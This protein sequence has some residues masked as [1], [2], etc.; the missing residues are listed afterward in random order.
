MNATASV[1]HVGDSLQDF[2]PERQS[3]MDSLGKSIQSMNPSL[4]EYLKPRCTHW[5]VSQCGLALEPAL[6]FE[7]RSP[8]P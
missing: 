8:L 6:I 5:L 7:R 4:V 1:S 2:P 3:R